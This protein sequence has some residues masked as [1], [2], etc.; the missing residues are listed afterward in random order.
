MRTCVPVGAGRLGQSW[1][2]FLNECITIVG[3]GGLVNVE[4][5]AAERFT[6]AKFALRSGQCPSFVASPRK[7]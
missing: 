7:H 3:F 6:C 4:I 1:P 2:N 5:M